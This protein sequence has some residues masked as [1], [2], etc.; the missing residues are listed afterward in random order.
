MAV[1]TAASYEETIED[2]E[3]TMGLVPG[4]MEV[5]P[6]EDLVHDWP[7]LKQYV[8]D[9]SEIPAKYREL[10][11]LAVAANIKC[12]YCVAFHRGAAQ[13]NGATDEELGE[14]AVLA[15]ITARWSAMIH[16]QQYDHDVFAEE[17]ER[18]GAFLQEE[19]AAD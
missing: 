18:I 19:Q 10:I 9:E 1:T 15:S 16:A 6:E 14:V 17:L 5:L 13:L 3:A 12:P 7:L 8:F 2:I 4:Y 11:G